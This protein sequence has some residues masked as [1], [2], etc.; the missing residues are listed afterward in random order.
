[1]HFDG[2]E[3]EAAIRVRSGPGNPVAGKDKSKLCQGCHGE[4]GN[5]V[6]SHVPKLSGQYGQYISKQLRNYQSG[7]RTHQIM[8]AMAATISDEELADISAY[9]ASQ[10]K[11]D[12]AAANF[13]LLGQRLFYHSDTTRGHMACV[14]CHGI[15]GKGLRPGTS[16][17]PVIGGQHKEYLLGQ[18]RSFKNDDRSNSPN[19]IMNKIAKALTDEELEALAEYVSEQ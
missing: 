15:S 13:N 2:D 14:N 17:F 4:A 11:M 6:E 16:M 9:F 18:L 1:M 3:S 12:G 7:V 5:S 19:A 8:N 10:H